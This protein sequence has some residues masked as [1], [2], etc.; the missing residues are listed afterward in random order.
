MFRWLCEEFIVS[1]TRPNAVYVVYLTWSWLYDW[2]K[3]S[4][5]PFPSSPIPSRRASWRPFTRLWIRGKSVYSRVPPARSVCGCAWDPSSHR[6]VWISKT[7][8][9]LVLQGKSLSLICGALTW[10]RDYEQQKKQEAAK[11]WM[12]RRRS[13]MLW[14]RRT[15]P[16]KHQSQTGCLSLC[17]RKQRETLWTS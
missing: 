13:V 17:R 11:L 10:L 6:L 5:F 9:C 14:R 1:L 8:L 3:S 16:A 2:S 7:F 15:A 4:R 12:D